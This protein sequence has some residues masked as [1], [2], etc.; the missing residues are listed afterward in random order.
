MSLIHTMETMIL[1]RG[2]LMIHSG[3][4]TFQKTNI[5]HTGNYFLELMLLLIILLSGVVIY[6]T[7]NIRRN[8]KPHKPAK[9]KSEL[10][11]FYFHL[12]CVFTFRVSYNYGFK[13]CVIFLFLDLIVVLTKVF[14]SL[15]FRDSFWMRYFFVY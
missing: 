4:L 11:I 5:P 3:S 8:L 10:F 2:L 6:I 14:Y 7:A 9:I 13:I 12:Y 1:P 15:Y